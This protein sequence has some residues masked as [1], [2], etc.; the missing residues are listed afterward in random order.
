[1]AVF[2]LAML[3]F[4]LIDVFVTKIEDVAIFIFRPA[5]LFA[6]GNAIWQSLHVRCPKCGADPHY[7]LDDRWGVRQHKVPS[8][9]PHCKLD[10]MK[11][12]NEESG[13]K[14]WT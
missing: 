11:P 4:L 3:I 6:I 13:W 5:L 12:F 10:F 9:C 1:M 7:K 2:P 14:R 8:A